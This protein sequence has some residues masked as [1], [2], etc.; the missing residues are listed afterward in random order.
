MSEVK[1]IPIPTRILTKKDDIV[2][3]IE[4][5]TKD[6]IG[7]DDVITVAE[8]VVAI[9]QGLYIRP[10]RPQNFSYGSILLPFHSRLW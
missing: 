5:Y 9:T 6:K 2:D 10:G 7:P 3:T 8:S 4:K 1:I